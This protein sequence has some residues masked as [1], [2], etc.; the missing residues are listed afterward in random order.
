[1]SE[2]CQNQTGRNDQKWLAISRER[3][4]PKAGWMPREYICPHRGQVS[5]SHLVPPMIMINDLDDDYDDDD[6]AGDEDTSPDGS[7]LLI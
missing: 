3:P 5:R 4:G 6:D 1:M 7:P 2:K